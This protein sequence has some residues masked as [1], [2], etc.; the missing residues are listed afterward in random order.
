ML[1][2]LEYLVINLEKNCI[3]FRDPDVSYKLRD[4]LSIAR[5][6]R[7]WWSVEFPT[8]YHAIRNF[9]ISFD[10]WGKE[11]AK[12]NLKVVIRGS[13]SDWVRKSHKKV[14]ERPRL[15]SGKISRVKSELVTF[16]NCGA[17]PAEFISG[18]AFFFFRRPSRP[19][20]LSWLRCFFFFLSLAL[21]VPDHFHCSDRSRLF[22][23][24]LFLVVNT[25]SF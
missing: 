10:Q 1:K 17:S 12:K 22:R 24:I 6:L 11:G 3:G 16:P 18:W 15:V 21:S 2:I 19:S 4:D 7:W 5:G 14:W 25:S 23:R 9:E 8:N 20:S 13:A